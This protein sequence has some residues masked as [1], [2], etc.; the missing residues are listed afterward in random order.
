MEW[1]VKVKDRKNYSI[2]TYEY[3]FGHYENGQ[4]YEEE[5]TDEALSESGRLIFDAMTRAPLHKGQAQWR[6]W[7]RQCGKF[8]VCLG[9]GQRLAQQLNEILNNP[10]NTYRDRDETGR[11]RER[12]DPPKEWDEYLHNSLR[13]REY[14]LAEAG[15]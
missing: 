4:F 8:F 9:D 5:L 15:Q 10:A 7:G 3:G 11:F 13:M 1:K 2:V 14:L 6:V 12:P